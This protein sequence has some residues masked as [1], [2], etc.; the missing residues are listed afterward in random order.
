M[1]NES[2]REVT[3]YIYLRAGTAKRLVKEVKLARNSTV[4]IVIRTDIETWGR[5]N[6]VT[7]FTIET[8]NE[9]DADNNPYTAELSV[10]AVEV[11]L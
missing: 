3:A 7:S 2:P 4:P 9:T 6:A 10:S 8:A 1:T 11:T 5:L